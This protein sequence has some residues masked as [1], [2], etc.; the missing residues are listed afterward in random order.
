MPWIDATVSGVGTLPR[1]ML[2]HRGYFA[3]ATVNLAAAVG[4]NLVVFTVVNALWLR[5]SP[6]PDSDRL[7][8]LPDGA[9]HTEDAPSLRIFR[10][11]VAGQVITY[12]FF[13]REFLHP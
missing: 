9:F 12:D 11:G 3:F 10:G 8:A 2:R 1:L 6:V 4:V 13:G 7:V 5:P